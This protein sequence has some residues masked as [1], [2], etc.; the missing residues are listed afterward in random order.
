MTAQERAGRAQRSGR[1]PRR[2]AGV[3]RTARAAAT[4]AGPW[5]AI[6]VAREDV[7]LL[8][9]PRCCACGVRVR[10]DDAAELLDGTLWCWDG[11]PESVRS[12]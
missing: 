8:P 6:G 2:A 1:V 12:R 3:Q 10:P 9:L 7:E 11:L 4:P 5:G